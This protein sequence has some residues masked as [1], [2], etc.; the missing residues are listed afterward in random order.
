M[1]QMRVVNEAKSID[2]DTSECRCPG[3]YKDECDAE[4]AQGCVWSD[5]GNSNGPWCQC[6]NPPVVDPT[7]PP[8][9][10]PIC[11]EAWTADCLACAASMTVEAFCADDANARISGCYSVTTAEPVVC[12]QAF[13]ADC[14]A[15]AASMTVEAFCANDANAR[16]S[17][18]YSVTTAEPVVCCQ[19]FAADCMACA[20]SMTVEA[21]CAS[22]PATPGCPGPPSGGPSG[23]PGL[24]SGG[25]SGGPGL[26]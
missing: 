26:H 23:G 18:C 12:C 19:A 10:A 5:A 6:L 16:I 2:L 22:T 14:M 20:A 11:C 7:I 3:Y 4:W 24:P 21:F 13:T 1:L 15:C 8:V 17:G 25:P 9:D